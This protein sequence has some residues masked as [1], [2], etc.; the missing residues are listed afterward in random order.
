MRRRRVT[1]FTL[2]E[3]LIAMTLVSFIL[4]LLFAGLRLATRSW[5]AGEQ[6]I[7]DTG[8]RALITNFLR[9][10]LEQ[11]YPLRWRVD[12][13]EVLA[14]EGAQ[15]ALAFVGRLPARQ[16][17]SGNHLLSLA[18]V[19][20]EGGRDLVLRWQLP[21]PQASDFS[22]L[23][24]AESKVLVRQVGELSFAYFGAESDL[25]EPDWVDRW[26]SATRLPKLIRV[27]LAGRD[28]A[29]WPDLVVAL[30]RAQA[31]FCLRWDSFYQRCMD[32]P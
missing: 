17:S 27:R 10:A 9:G 20:G 11:I 22:A 4:V 12:G 29:A 14:F 3:L 15:Q 28:G 18:L 24:G 16:G 21:S 19:D 31:Q 2:L 6:R 1:G 7:V 8:E 30:A 5:D 32:R 13:Q 23:E 26:S 25:A